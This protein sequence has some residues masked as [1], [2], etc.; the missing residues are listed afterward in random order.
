MQVHRHQPRVRRL[1]GAAAAA[2]RASARLRSDGAHRQAGHLRLAV[3]RVFGDGRP[4]VLAA[5]GSSRV[6]EPADDSGPQPSTLSG[7]EGGCR[8]RD[9]RPVSRASSS[10]CTKVEREGE[11]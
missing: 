11:R 10:A 8:Q 3:Q 1:G 4:R 2:R 5:V 7:T 9:T 6:V